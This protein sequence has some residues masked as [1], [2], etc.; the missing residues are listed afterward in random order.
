MLLMGGVV[1]LLSPTTGTTVHTVCRG[2]NINVIFNDATTFNCNA[3]Y[4]ANYPPNAPVQ[5]PNEQV[6][7]QQIVYN[8]PIGG[9][10]IPNVSVNGVPVTG[11]GGANIISNYQDPRGV[12][13]MLPLVVVNDPRRRATLPI[14]APGG[15]GAG[16]PQVGDEFEIT[17]RYWN[18]CNPYDNP[19]VPGPPA[20]PINGDF[21]PVERVALIRIIDA[22]NPPTVTPPGPFCENDWPP[23]F[24][25][26]AT[27]SGSGTLTYTWYRD[28]ALTQVLQGPSTDNTFNPVTEGPTP[29]INK[30]V[31]GSQTFTRYVTV[32]QGSNNCT[33]QPTTITIRIDD[34]NTPGTIAHPLGASPITICNADDPVAFTSPVAGTGGGP[35]GTFTY[36]W[37]NAS[38]SGGPYSNITGANSA[39][40]NPSPADIAAGRFFRRRVRSGN[41]ADEF[42]NIIEFRIDTPVTGGTIG[43]NQTI[44]ASPG[45]P[46]NLFNLTSPTGGSHTGIYNFQWEESTTSVSGPFNT[47]SGA[48]SNSYNPPSGVTTTTYYRRRVNSGVC[49]ADGPDANSDPDNIAYSN[50]I[51]VTVDQAVVPGSIG[52]AQIICSGQDPGVLTEVTGPSGGNGST[53]AFLWE[54]SATGGGVGF[55]AAPGANT[56]PTYDPPV[57]TAT[58]YYR[59]QVTSGFCPPTFSNEI[60]VT[61]N[62]LPTA[63]VSGGGSVCSGTPAPDIVWTFT[64]TPPFDFTITLAP[65]APINVTGH[66]AMTYTIAAPN[67]PVNTTYTL[68]ALDDDNNCT[69][70]SLG[71]AVAVNIQSTPPPTV[72]NFT[73]QPAVCDDGGAT[74]PP[75]AILDLLPN[76]TE[77]YAITYRLLQVST[78]TFL[79]GS[80]NFTGSSTGA[81]IIN[82]APTYAQFGA[83]P[84]D[85]QGYQVVITAIQNTVTL[86]AGAVPINGPILIINP[87]PAAPTGPVANTACSADA[88]GAPIRVDTPAAG[89]SILWS[90]TAAPTFTAA[91]GVTGGTRG[92]TFTP[93]SNATATYHAFTQND[94]TL[95]R[96]AGSIAVNHTA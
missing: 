93:T 89:F 6:R 69:G 34:T 16:F 62:P 27:G 23:N 81:G 25:F 66:N 52:N 53:Y 1:Q 74:N 44:C 86:C 33:S 18:F 64:G 57:L 21:P 4:P 43:S 78:G 85:P 87:R 73:A 17:L 83:F 24:N 76:S 50:V 68:T 80:I 70:T 32:T 9:A 8:T 48:T 41:C 12:F 58:R 56:N 79:P 54:E 77:N 88:T 91:S 13:Q 90:S 39:T 60:Q 2:D 55:A 82:L 7:W 40:F 26:T 5:T 36:Q 61:V 31:T 28:A 37:Q 45:D 65:G 42:S 38:A 29:R 22:P 19:A 72:E 94:A 10:K 14:T 71:G 35:G 51:T 75:D 92:D 46:A 63:T 59:R 96:S 49:S 95:C 3:A 30:T 15:L 11:A 47:I 20:D 67:P 84:D